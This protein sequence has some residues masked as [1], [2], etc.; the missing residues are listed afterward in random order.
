VKSKGNHPNAAQV[1]WREAVRELGSVISGGPAVIHHPIGVTGKHNKVAIGHWWIIPL[2]DVEH[3]QLHQGRWANRK[4][5][6]KE[7][8]GLVCAAM[9]KANPDASQPSEEVCQAIWDYHL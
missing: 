9:T 3:K 8:F 2:T 6:E 4:K 5:W 1:R 7:F